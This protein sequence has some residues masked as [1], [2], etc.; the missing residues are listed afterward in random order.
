M[1]YRTQLQKLLIDKTKSLR[2]KEAALWLLHIPKWWLCQTKLNHCRLKKWFLWFHN[3]FSTVRKFGLQFSFCSTSQEKKLHFVL[4]CF[5][6]RFSTQSIESNTICTKTVDKSIWSTS[7][8]LWCLSMERFNT[9]YKS[10]TSS[11]ATGFDC[12]L[13]TIWHS[14][15]SFSFVFLQQFRYLWV[16]IF[17]DNWSMLQQQYFPISMLEKN[18]DWK[19]FCQIV[20]NYFFSAKFSKNFFPNCHQ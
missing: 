7:N 9:K 15:V 1:V 16:D 5:V 2:Q 20:C 11:D 6:F 12:V 13:E 10:R 4:F 17:Y 8:T 3:K 18:W 19:F 14:K